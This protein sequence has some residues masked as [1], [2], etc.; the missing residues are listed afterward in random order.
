MTIAH[1]H[2]FHFMGHMGY[3][4]TKNAANNVCPVDIA[5]IFS[6]SQ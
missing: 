5:N 3:G 4:Q 1:P 2:M 6:S